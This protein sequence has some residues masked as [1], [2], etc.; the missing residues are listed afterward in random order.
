MK[1]VLAW[2]SGWEQGQGQPSQE[3]ETGQQGKMSRDK[4]QRD[5]YSRGHIG[6]VR[7]AGGS[8]QHLC[9]PQGLASPSP[10]KIGLELIH[11]II[12]LRV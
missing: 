7:A 10:G 5:S 6:K 3:A 9:Q 8:A 4:T 11:Q 1:P 12:F 2:D